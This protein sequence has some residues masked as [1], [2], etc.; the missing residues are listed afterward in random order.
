LGKL[1][2]TDIFE[3][4]K[5]NHSYVW[6]FGPHVLGKLTHTDIFEMVK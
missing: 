5:Q 2:H 4:V 6:L 3:V 1:T